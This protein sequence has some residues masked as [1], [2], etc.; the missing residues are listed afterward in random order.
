MV[1]I[2]LGIVGGYF[3][4]RALVG[5]VAETISSLYVL[6]SVREIVA[7]SLGSDE[8]TAARTRVRSRRRLVTGAGCG[9]DRSDRN[10]APGNTDRTG[11]R[12]FPGWIIG[13]GLALLLSLALSFLALETGPAW[14][15]FGAAFLVL[16]GFSLV[17]PATTSGFSRAVCALVREQGGAPTGGA[18]FETHSPA[19]LGHNRGAG[20]R[21]GDDRRSCGDGVFVST[22]SRLTGSITP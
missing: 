19:Q 6:V 10:I 8:C 14:L 5:T 21:R 9:S 3:L 16:A 15:G 13:G 22:D 20:G 11:D 2:L 4:A 17:A 7:T 18:E 1:G 12:A